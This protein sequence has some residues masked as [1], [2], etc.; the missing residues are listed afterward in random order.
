[1]TTEAR[2]RF[3]LL[4]VLFVTAACSGTRSTHEAATPPVVA[5][6]MSSEEYALACAHDPRAR[7]RLYGC[8]DGRFSGP[9]MII[10]GAPIIVDTSARGRARRDSTLTALRGRVIDSVRYLQPD[11]AIKVLGSRGRDGAVC[12][13]TRNQ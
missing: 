7:L 6:A 11:S 8:N 9:L 1:M 4:T 2:A 12:I 10:D 3:F 13:W 5:T